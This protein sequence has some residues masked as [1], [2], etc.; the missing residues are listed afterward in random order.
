M[1]LVGALVV[2]LVAGPIF[3][4]VRTKNLYSSTTVRKIF[5]VLGIEYIYIYI[6]LRHL[7]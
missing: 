7:D 3:D 5:H 1:P 6:E 4:F 2:H